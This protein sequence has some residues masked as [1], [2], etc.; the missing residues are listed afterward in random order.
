VS[1]IKKDITYL[2]VPALL[3]IEPTQFTGCK[4]ASIF[5]NNLSSPIDSTYLIEWD[6]GDG[7]K[8]NKIS[9]THTYDSTGL[10]NVKINITSPIGCTT[11]RSYGD[12]IEILDKPYAEFDYFPKELNIFNKT[13]SFTNLSEREISWN[14]NFGG[15]GV[16]FVEN[17]THTFPDS[18]L[19]EVKLVAFH[20]NG[21][22]D[23]SSALLDIKPLVSLDMPNAFTPNNDGLN[24]D[25]K[26]FGYLDGVTNFKMS[27]FNRWGD[28]IF[29]TDDSSQG[30][31]G[32]K[33]NEGVLSP[34]GV[35]VYTI[36]Y[37]TP[38]GEKKELKGHVTLIR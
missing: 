30:W 13:V 33:N 34:Q 23:T 1:A 5:F 32:Q 25:F 36:E 20:E 15:S 22:T 3:V 31:N 9:P 35:Y 19:Y 7:K 12:W 37:N 6:F 24:D 11:S 8:S 26:G 17:P 27:I 2:P 14:W 21:C 4:P 18:G 38:R 29:E 28:M 10:Y 16:S